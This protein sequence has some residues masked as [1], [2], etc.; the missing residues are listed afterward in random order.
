MLAV[1]G[2]LPTGPWGY[3][4]KWDGYRCCLRVGPSGEARLTSRNGNDLTATYPELAHFPPALLDGRPGVLDGEIVALDGSGRPDFARLQRRHQRQPDSSTL[5]ET[6]VTFFAFD[7]LLYHG[8]WLL[9]EPY[10]RRRGVLAGLPAAPGR[11]VVPPAYTAADIAPG[12]LLDIARRHSLEGLI[13]KRLD[14]RYQPGRRSPSWVKKALSRTQE[15][16]VGGW[17]PG[18]GHRSGTIGSLLLGAYDAQGHLRYI[19]HVGSGFTDAVLADLRDRLA[20]LQRPTSPFADPVPRADA[21]VARWVE[22]RL[23]GD[24]A[25]RTW[26]RDG[27]LRQPSWRGLRPDKSP[28]QVTLPPVLP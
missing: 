2:E 13:A 3:E 12:D 27:R 21:R 18:K 17:Q 15:A 14:S 20:P 24:V 8:A 26:T 22:P 7:V 11:V 9:A 4:F 23:V 1:E 5:D 6:P 16:V 25:F 10:E 19:G 28:T